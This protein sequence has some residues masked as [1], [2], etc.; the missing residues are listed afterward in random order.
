MRP[1]G[2]N[3]KEWNVNLWVVETAR[4]AIEFVLAKMLP[5]ICCH[6]DQGICQQAFAVELVPKAAELFVNVCNAIV[7]R[8][9]H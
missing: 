4:M 3:C 7:V 6:Y 1:I 8:I 2:K 5:V 9:V